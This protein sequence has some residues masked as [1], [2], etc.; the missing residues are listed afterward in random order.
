MD[1]DRRIE[2][3]RRAGWDPDDGPAPHE[4]AL[5]PP[6]DPALGHNGVPAPQPGDPDFPGEPPVS[7]L[8]PRTALPRVSEML[9]ATLDEHWSNVGFREGPNNENPWG[10]EQG[11]KKAKYCES[12]ACMVAHHN[13]YRWWPESQFGEKGFAYTVFHVQVGEAHGEV[14]L[15]RTSRGD[16][17]DVLQGDL[18]YYDWDLNG[19]VDHV[20][21]AIEARIGGGRTHNIGYNTG[22]PE[23][24]HE[25]WRDAK[26][27]RC[28][29]R[30]SL[31]SHEEEEDLDV[32]IFGV[33]SDDPT[34]NGGWLL[35]GDGRA[36]QIPGPDDLA[37]LKRMGIRDAGELTV[38]FL[39]RFERV[40]PL[41][42]NPP[43]P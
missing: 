28:R 35:A 25:L 17:A 1:Q 2:A 19:V 6:I 27:L 30:P 29:L 9:P 8:R 5:P 26:F 11:V 14:R 38:E 22:S 7:G 39:K 12:A 41:L 32:F 13:G 18:L 33:T 24:C 36:H 15:D 3:A 4:H 31:Y 43:Q 21:T 42:E 34:M 10:P 40:H 23:G 16:P 37:A 20:E